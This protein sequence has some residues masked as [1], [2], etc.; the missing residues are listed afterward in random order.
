MTIS[1]S[2]EIIPL[3][4]ILIVNSIIDMYIIPT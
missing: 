1:F 2:E 3:P 4:D